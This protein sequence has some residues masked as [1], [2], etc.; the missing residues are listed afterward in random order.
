MT[1]LLPRTYETCRTHRQPTAR[2]HM[3]DRP[4]VRHNVGSG[5]GNTIC[6]GRAFTA[7][8]QVVR[9][10]VWSATRSSLSEIGPS[11]DRKGTML[12]RD[13]GA[14]VVTDR[15]ARGFRFAGAHLHLHAVGRPA[16]RRWLPSA[17]QTGT[18]L[19]PACA[20]TCRS[21]GRDTPANR[22]QPDREISPLIPAL[23]IHDGAPC[24][25]RSFIPI[26]PSAFAPTA[27]R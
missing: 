23:P 10:E 9:R 7:S 12:R 4:R 22:R 27:A 21:R 13:G 6:P 25:R 17:S 18:T 26:P 1:I 3:E 14:A 15:C 20:A 11:D 5:G 2:S 16:G 24:S 19:A 8:L